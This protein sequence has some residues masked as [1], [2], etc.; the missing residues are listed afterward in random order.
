MNS[1]TENRLV[2]RHWSARRRR[3]AWI[4]AGVA[5][6]GVAIALIVNATRHNL[7]F[8]Y[9]PTQIAAHQAPLGRMFRVGGLV[10]KGSLYHGS[11]ALDI[12]FIVTDTAHSIPV[13]YRGVLP[14]MF[15][16]GKG[17]V[18]QGRLGPDGVF[19]A[20]QVLAKHD[21]NYMPPNVASALQAA[22]AAKSPATVAGR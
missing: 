7:V 10:E 18:A 3:F 13:A 1:L 2:V 22:R 4:L 6:L 21:A 11:N 14:D 5:C 9:S 16:P 19:H 20:D 12:R 15:E 8:F 17:V